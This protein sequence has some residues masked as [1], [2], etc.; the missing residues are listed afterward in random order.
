MD[1]V[2]ILDNYRLAVV[3]DAEGMRILAVLFRSGPQS[4]QQLKGHLSAELRPLRNKLSELFRANLVRILANELWATTELSDQILGRLGITELAARSLL[5]EQ[6]IREADKGFLAACAESRSFHDKSWPKYQAAA[7]RAL[8]ELGGIS[9]PYRRN[10]LYGVIVGLDTE[11]QKLGGDG[12]CRSVVDWHS[13]R[14]SDLWVQWGSD[15]RDDLALYSRRCRYGRELALESDG[16]FMDPGGSKPG[17]L[18]ALLLFL[19]T[20]GAITSGT[21]DRA[22]TAAAGLNPNTSSYVW[23]SLNATLPGSETQLGKLLQLLGLTKSRDAAS[24]KVR[25]QL[26]LDKIFWRAHEAVPDFLLVPGGAPDMPRVPGQEGAWLERTL[27]SV[28]GQIDAGEYDHLP[29]PART[30]LL[31]L[32]DTTRTAFHERSSAMDQAERE[33]G[34]G[35]S[36]KAGRMPSPPRLSTGKKESA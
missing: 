27:L 24:P 2:T 14:K 26:L 18:P 29:A 12:Y 25:F 36:L 20:S 23:E 8:D 32:F 31:G 11:A 7:L 1:A 35:T 30:K 3:N 5:E 13:A 33:G 16:L 34:E 28:R 15:W 4:E 21:P 17:K 19:R 6:D 10:L 9:S 22:M